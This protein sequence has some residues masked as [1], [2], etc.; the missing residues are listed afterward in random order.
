MGSRWHHYK[1][2]KPLL[3]RMTTQW[4]T[5]PCWT[6]AWVRSKPSVVIVSLTMKFCGCW[7]L[8]NSLDSSN[9]HTSSKSLL[10]SHLIQEVFSDHLI[11][12]SSPLPTFSLCPSLALFP[13]LDLFISIDWK[14]VKVGTLLCSLIHQLAT[15]IVS[16]QCRWPLAICWIHDYLL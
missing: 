9:R 7:L 13:S 14:L 16:A 11:Q 5:S 1:M 3:A 12:K 10:K 2:A 15:S 6:S 4:L 8:Q